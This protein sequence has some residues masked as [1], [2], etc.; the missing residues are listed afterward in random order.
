MATRDGVNIFGCV[1]GHRTDIQRSIAFYSR[2][3]NAGAVSSG[4]SSIAVVA[5]ADTDKVAARRSPSR[6]KSA[7]YS[8]DG[9]LSGLSNLPGCD[10]PRVHEARTT[11]RLVECDKTEH[12]QHRCFGER[13]I[14]LSDVEQLCPR[15]KK[16]S[17]AFGWN[18]SY[19]KRLVYDRP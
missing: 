17:S 18:P 2:L 11:K 3:D 4:N 14:Q 15:A 13:K 8:I 12:Q 6:S 5:T 1:L 16:T 7:P 10:Q 19:R 9:D